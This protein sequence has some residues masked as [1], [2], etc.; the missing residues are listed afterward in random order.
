MMELLQ[1]CVK[2][3]ESN[4]DLFYFMEDALM[5]LD[6]ANETVT[7]NFPLYFALHLTNFFGFQLNT[8]DAKKNHICTALINW[9][10][11]KW[12]KVKTKI[13]G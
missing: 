6:Q 5:Q 3:P 1:K 7:A 11:K 9:Q 8:E 13:N 10:I 2:Q 4:P 12:E